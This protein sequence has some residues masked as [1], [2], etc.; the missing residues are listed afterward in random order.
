[1]KPAKFAASVAIYGGTLLWMLG[2]VS[3]FPRAA[4]LVSNVTAGALVVELV[5]I[6]TQAVRGTTSH[7][8]VSTP[9][10]SMLFSIMGAF[11][12]FVWAMNLVA[13]GLAMRERFEDRLFG[14]SLRLGLVLTLTGAVSGVLMTQPTPEQRAEMAAGASPNVVG[15]HAVGV[16]DGGPG[17]PGV[18]WSVEG[19]DLRVAHFVGLHGL[20]AIPLLGW[21]LRRRSGSSEARRVGLLFVGAGGYLGLVALLTVQALRGQPLVAPD[22]VTLASLGTLV[23]AV[24][25]AALAVVARTRTSAGAR[26]DPLGSPSL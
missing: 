4:R 26:L 14:W 1:L 16:P 3:S 22:A 24:L 20:Q 18:G 10:D 17:L 13:A 9:L 23:L 7:F 11:I 8:N 21:L 12:V 5:V 25:A 15:A 6:V 19:G 2:H